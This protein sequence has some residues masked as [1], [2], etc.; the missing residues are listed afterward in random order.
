MT[1]KKA[2]LVE[3]ATMKAIRKKPGFDIDT[4]SGFFVLCLFIF[5]N[6]E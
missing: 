5:V 4:N 6:D 3:Q 1:R 2:P